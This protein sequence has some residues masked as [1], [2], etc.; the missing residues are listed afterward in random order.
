M[1]TTGVN[2]QVSALGN[3]MSHIPLQVLL[4]PINKLKYIDSICI[5]VC[6]HYK[7]C[8]CLWHLDYMHMFTYDIYHI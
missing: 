7:P 6:K 1:N 3:S 2:E 5:G 4:F 8:T